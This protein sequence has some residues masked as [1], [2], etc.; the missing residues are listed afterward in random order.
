MRRSLTM[1]L[2]AA[3]SLFGCA[4]SAESIPVPPGMATAIFAGGCFWCVE[5][6]FEKLPG[7]I[8]AESGYIGGST[9][10]PTYEQVSHGETGHTEAVRVIYDP[11]KVGYTQLLDHFWR[12]IDPTVKDRQFC[13]KGNQYR[14]GI[15][16]QND[17]ERKLA[18]ASRDELLK[19]GRFARIE[20]EI[21]PAWKFWPAEGY[22]QDY[23]K[24]NPV[25]YSFYRYAC[26][27]DARVELL[28]SGK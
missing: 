16:Y 24:K 22:H 26:G 14:S 27:R 13:D 12:H 25:R 1:A 8:E 5:Q 17:A 4:V 28:W 6:D 2:L 21:A 3:G 20:T 19:S 7:V 23:Y 9:P 15:Y 11:R 10:F 18:E